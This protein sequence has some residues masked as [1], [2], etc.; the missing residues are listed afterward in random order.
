MNPRAH[1]AL[2]TLQDSLYKRPLRWSVWLDDRTDL[3]E[4]LVRAL[5]PTF[6][7]DLLGVTPR[8]WTLWA[9]TQPWHRRQP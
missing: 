1:T 3:V 7:R 8:A 5:G 9:P 2:F 6:T 4:V